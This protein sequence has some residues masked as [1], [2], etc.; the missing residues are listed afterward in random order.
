MPTPSQLT[1]DID[2]SP[3]AADAA[4]APAWAD[5][6]RAAVE[7]AVR[8]GLT[9][10]AADLVTHYGLPEPTHPNQWGAAF[11]TFAHEGLITKAFASPSRRTTVAGS[12]V[13]NWSGTHDIPKAA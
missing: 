10:Q 12:L 9:F 2:T 3:Q 1:L 6:C 5:Q 7:L 4:P 8:A 11:S 13:W